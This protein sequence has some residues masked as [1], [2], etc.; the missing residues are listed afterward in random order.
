MDHLSRGPS[1]HAEFSKWLAEGAIKYSET[2][3]EGI[4]DAPKAFVDLL[5]A[6]LRNQAAWNFAPTYFIRSQ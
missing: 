3:I 4:E 6:Y 2:I 1:F 5:C